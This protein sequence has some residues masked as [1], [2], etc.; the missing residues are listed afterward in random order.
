MKLHADQ[1]RRDL[2]LTPGDAVWLKIHP[3][4]QKSV[5]RSRCE[6]L[7]PCFYGPLKV[8]RRI[9]KVSY[10]LELPSTTKIHPVFHISLLRPA[11]GLQATSPPPPLPL[12]A[13]MEFLLTPSRELQHRWTP[14]K[15][16]EHLIQWENHTPE[17]ATWEDYDLLAAQFPD[18][19]LEGKS[20]FQRGRN[21]SDTNR[22]GS[23]YSRKNKRIRI[24]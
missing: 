22:Y 8:L 10:E 18:F 23:V 24:S 7:S 9:S 6:K 5:S 13:D 19:R 17:D 16:L 20:F 3:Y 4:C 14:A 1:H 2:E 21:D 11:L 15:Q 12:S